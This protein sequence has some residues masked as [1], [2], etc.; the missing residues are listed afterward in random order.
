MKI[1]YFI[2]ALKF[3]VNTSPTQLRIQKLLHS[4]PFRFSF[5]WFEVNK[6]SV[7]GCARVHWRSQSEQQCCYRSRWLV[8]KFCKPILTVII[9]NG[10]TGRSF[11]LYGIMCSHWAIFRSLYYFR[12][13]TSL[14]N[15]KA[16]EDRAR[17]V[18]SRT[19]SYCVYRMASFRCI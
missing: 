17:Q 1:L 4:F 7:C 18:S 10:W 5:R 16:S 2:T 12:S 14:L 13:H 3:L 11:I 19:L 9:S 8:R 15:H 6:I